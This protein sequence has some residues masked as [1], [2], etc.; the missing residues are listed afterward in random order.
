MADVIK[1]PRTDWGR[2]LLRDSLVWG[3]ERTYGDLVPVIDW[4][5]LAVD[6]Q[7]VD[8]RFFGAANDEAA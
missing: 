7:R 2:A 1:L 3:L 8:R 4:D 6:C 5:V